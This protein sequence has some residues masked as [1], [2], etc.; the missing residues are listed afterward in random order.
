M[1]AQAERRSALETRAINLAAYAERSLGDF[2]A[3][4]FRQALEERIRSR[5]ILSVLIAVGA[6]FVIGRLLRS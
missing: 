5:P 2:D 4:A 6:G 1:T 3:E